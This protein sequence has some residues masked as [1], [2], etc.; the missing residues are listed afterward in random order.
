MAASQSSQSFTTHINRQHACLA[1]H[2]IHVCPIDTQPQFPR[3]APVCARPP[4]SGGDELGC[5]ATVSL[6]PCKWVKNDSLCH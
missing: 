3:L 1:L 2:N 6:R 4:F 5:R